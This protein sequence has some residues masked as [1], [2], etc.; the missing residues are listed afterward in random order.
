MKN[1]LKINIWTCLLLISMVGTQISCSSAKRQEMAASREEAFND[2]KN[3]VASAEK[4]VT[5]DA[6]DAAEKWKENT[7]QLESTYKEKENKLEGFADDWSDERKAEIA[8]LKTRWKNNWEKRESEHQARLASKAQASATSKNG[9]VAADFNTT[10]IATMPATSM[11]MVFE[12]FV[13]RIQANKDNYTR[14]D[15]L[16]IGTYYEALEARREIVE[17]DLTDK[18]K[19][20]IAKAKTQYAAIKGASLAAPAMK[21]AA[22]EVKDATKAGAK[23]VGEAAEKVG[24]EVKSGTKKAVKKADEKLD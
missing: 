23:K 5:N 6:E 16:T 12:N 20:E 13:S 9:G 19:F 8:T 2:F 14:E 18:D 15:W 17:D 11:R 4:R 24:T 21:E 10:D 3:Y 7:A 1:L 22:S